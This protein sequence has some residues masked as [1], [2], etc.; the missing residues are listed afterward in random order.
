MRQPEREIPARPSSLVDIVD[1]NPSKEELMTLR[2]DCED[3]LGKHGKE[4]GGGVFGPRKRIRTDEINVKTRAGDIL[5]RVGRY[6]GRKKSD[7]QQDINIGI[8]MRT[9]DNELVVLQLLGDGTARFRLDHGRIVDGYAWYH[10]ESPTK[11]DVALHAEA[12]KI[13]AEQLVKP[14]NASR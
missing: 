10:K 1:V 11:K 13:A 4:Y 5:L 14:T 6:K 3:F 8:G 7:L 2:R 12:L 9:G